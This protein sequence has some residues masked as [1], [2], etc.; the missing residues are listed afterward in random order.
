[1]KFP[2]PWLAMGLGMVQDLLCHTV[3]TTYNNPILPGFN[4]DPSCIFVPEW[5]DMFFCTTSS[6]LTFPGHPIF[7]SKDLTNWK[8]SSHVIT[9]DDQVPEL[10]RNAGQNEGLWAPTMRYH[11]GVFYYITSYV[12]WAEGWGPIILLFTTTD[13]FDD[14][15][16]SD[17]LRI[18]NPEKEID[19]DIFFD[20]N[21]KV[22]MGVARGIFLHE[23]N[24]TDGSIIKTH[25]VWNG[26][27][28]RNPEGPNLF[29]EYGY[30]YL[31]IGEGGTE[32]NHSASIARATNIEGPY[33]GY[34]H[35]PVLTA[36]DTDNFFQ[37]VG[38]VDY[39]RDMNGNWWCTA[40]ATRSG[41]EWEIYPMGRELVLTPVTWPEGGWPTVDP[42]FG[43]MQGP[44]PPKNKEIP[45]D[46]YWVDDGDEEDFKPG[47]ALPRSFLF[48]RPP[49]TSLFEISPPDH[50]NTLR[51]SP[52]RVNLTTDGEGFDP[53]E[54][55]FAFVARKQSASM[56]HFTVDVSFKPTDLDEEAGLSVFL[57]QYQHIDMSIVN[58]P[59]CADGKLVPKL[60]MSVD[61]SGQPEVDPIA[62]RLTP[63]PEGWLGK[64]V[65]LAISTTKDH[66]YVLSAT[67]T[68]EDDGE[69]VLGSV[70]A[71]VISGG[72]GPFHGKF[73][74]AMANTSELTYIK[75]LWWAPMPRA[76][77]AAARLRRTSAAGGTRL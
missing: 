62:T 51:I 68:G 55:G 18:D 44:L 49:K 53:K 3:N 33:E 41:P 9:R 73:P 7:A 27:G 66:R 76:T 20:D 50:P 29:K 39:F 11:K 47:S 13:P 43:T 21:G 74:L 65:R 52:S 72:L 64:P 77:A 31:S 46:G 10:Y 69:I 59:S 56:F 71:K 34:E 63:V 67:S 14:A 17:P 54:D 35:N 40:L 22:Y 57:T 4:P 16:W 5:D 2:H 6:F 48:W 24:V 32:T 12:S 61:T 30:Y 60:K 38:H 23:I 70:T 58:R 25:E 37:T 42:V 75:A 1:M 19:P 28:V 45:G 15:A 36:K 26:T 8:L